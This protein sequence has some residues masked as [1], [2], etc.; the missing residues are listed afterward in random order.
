MQSC[1]IIDC[2]LYSEKRKV[3]IKSP[4]HNDPL[5]QQAAKVGLETEMLLLSGVL[6]GR[7]GI[8]QLVDR[9]TLIEEPD[10]IQ[11]AVL[12]YGEKT[13]HGFH[14]VEKGRLSPNQV[15]TAAR[16]LLKAL[17]FIHEKGIVHTG[18]R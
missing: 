6:K 14:I 16:Q 2:P 13:L 9:I 5:H 15:K 3:V 1:S 17:A 4:L 8:R 11:A 18:K 12:E 7:S 10:Q